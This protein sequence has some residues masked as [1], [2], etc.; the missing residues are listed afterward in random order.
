MEVLGFLKVRR[1]I[2]GWRDDAVVKRTSCPF[3]GSRVQ[4][5]A[6]TWQSAIPVPGNLSPCSACMWL[7]YIHVSKTATHRKLNK[8]KR[9]RSVVT[10]HENDKTETPFLRG[11][12]VR[13]VRGGAQCGSQLLMTFEEQ[14]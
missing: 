1:Q 11:R 2:A 10:S 8:S 14:F 3:T 6:P 7:T 12:E 5:P 13:G 4:L 9:D